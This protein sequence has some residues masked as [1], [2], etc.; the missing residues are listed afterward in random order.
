M[1]PEQIEHLI[2]PIIHNKADYTKGNRLQSDPGKHGMPRF[3]MVGN[4][5]LTWL[6]RIESGY[7]HVSDTQ[8]GFTAISKK[9][10]STI[11]TGF[12]SYYGYLNDVLARLNVYEFKVLDIP[13]P[14]K[15]GK[16]KSK[17]KLHR[18]IPKVSLIL[19]RI[20]VWRLKVKYFKILRNKNNRPTSLQRIT[21]G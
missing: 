7:W 13:M 10:L 17:I 3:R 19:F 5:L 9:A 21:K 14:A 6:T 2:K 18:F 15:Y 20:F 8:N 12:C 11:D 4:H 1:P 16:E